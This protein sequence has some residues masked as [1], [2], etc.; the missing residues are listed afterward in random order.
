MGR[1]ANN[2][3]NEN[4]QGEAW[5][6]NGGMMLRGDTVAVATGD[7]VVGLVDDV[8]ADDAVAV[9]QMKTPLL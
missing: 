2:I 3:G 5:D 4:K 9:L 1:T 6:L 7:T 8:I